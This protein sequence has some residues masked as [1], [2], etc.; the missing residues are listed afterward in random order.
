MRLALP[1]IQK[2]AA[3]SLVTPDITL[4]LREANTRA[5]AFRAVGAP[6]QE[7]AE[8]Y[9]DR[10]SKREMQEAIMSTHKRDKDFV[11]NY[12]G[13]EE[14]S[15]MDTDDLNFM[16]L[17]DE[18][19]V[20]DV[21]SSV[22]S[23]RIYAEWRKRNYEDAV[24]EAASQLSSESAR[25]DFI[26][27]HKRRGESNYAQDAV[28]ST[29]QQIKYNARKTMEK[30]DQ[31]MLNRDFE[32]A[33]MAV[34][35]SGMSE[36]ATSRTHKLID[37]REQVDYFNEVLEK[38][39]VEVMTS[40]LESLKQ[41]DPAL[42]SMLDATSQKALANQ[43]RTAINTENTAIRSAANTS[44]QIQV[45]DAKSQIADMWGNKPVNLDEFASNYLAVKAKHPVVAREM[46]WTQKHQPT[47]NKIMM[48]PPSAQ[49]STLEELKKASK[50][51][52]EASY[53]IGKLE[54]SIAAGQVAR[55]TDATKWAKDTGFVAY[56]PIDY[57][58]PESAQQSLKARIKPILSIQRRFGSF[59]GFLEKDELVE[60][61]SRLEN[62]PNKLE[63]F[64]AINGALGEYAEP[65]YE[66]LKQYNIGETS[67][68]AG[69]IMT[70]GPAYK[71][72][73]ENILK[74]ANLRK[75]DNLTQLKMKDASQELDAFAVERFGGIFT[76]NKKQQ[77]LNIEAFKDVYAV[78]GDK[79]EAFQQLTGGT[80]DYNGYTIQ[81]PVPGMSGWQYRSFI[82]DITP[83]YWALPKMRAYGWTPEQLRKNVI[84]GNL[85][86]AGAGRGVSYLETEDGM[87]V[88]QM[89]GVSDFMFTF[90]PE[91]PTKSAAH[92]ESVS[93]KNARIAEEKRIAKEKRAE[94]SGGMA[95]S[96]IERWT[97]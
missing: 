8:K 20:T 94:E 91:A 84:N 46:E 89:D 67:S 68:L 52:R 43:L 34:D 49:V 96:L 97:D 31:S 65:F 29:S 13:Q 41:N 72:V 9:V 45:A 50:G 25:Q 58:S 2:G 73:A 78:T 22:P 24:E 10:E 15:V 37:T 77:S 80:I 71:P 60:F 39:D 27:E 23:H 7:A 47:I 83:E 1:K 16:D 48:A 62:A 11:A 3:A 38:R 87:R 53:L 26:F 88:K 69:Q 51:G 61:G 74:G 81:A 66:Q 59:T 40:A 92:K 12:G 36:E 75:T 56:D 32:S 57:S 35:T 42:T 70:W 95:R 30:V 21:A 54:T 79:E 64:G 5:A 76:G 55:R 82:K 63:F 85:K 4:P 90:D 93:E 17:A 6:L 33:R 44:T 19:G 86:Q 14:F 28:A 18:M